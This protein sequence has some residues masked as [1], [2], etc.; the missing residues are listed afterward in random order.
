M[1]DEQLSRDLVDSQGWSRLGDTFE[2]SELKIIEQMTSHCG[3][4]GQLVSERNK[5]ADYRCPKCSSD[6]AAINKLGIP[7]H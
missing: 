3:C 6:A 7:F 5:A 2:P 4:G 1:N